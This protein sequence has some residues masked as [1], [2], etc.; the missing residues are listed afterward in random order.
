ML[1]DKFYVLS[2]KMRTLMMESLMCLLLQTRLTKLVE[3]TLKDIA[4][5]VVSNKFLTGPTT[6]RKYTME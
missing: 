5:L 2:N 6:K 1:T 3:G 4:S